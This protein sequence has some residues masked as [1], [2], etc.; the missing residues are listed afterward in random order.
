MYPVH[1]SGLNVIFFFQALISQPLSFVHNCDDQSCLHVSPQYM[2]FHILTFTYCI[3]LY[4]FPPRTLDRNTSTNKMVEMRV[5]LF[6]PRASAFDLHINLV[7]RVY[8]TV[9]RN[10]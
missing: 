8:R 2:I 10:L 7:P 3:F 5:T 6:K 9:T 1:A 4:I